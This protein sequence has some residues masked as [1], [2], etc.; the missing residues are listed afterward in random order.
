MHFPFKLMILSKRLI[1]WYLHNKRDLP[2]RNTLNPYNIKFFMNIR[3]YLKMK[4]AHY[5][6]EANPEDLPTY[7]RMDLN[8]SKAIDENAVVTLDIRNLLDR[9]NH[10]PSLYGAEDGIEEPGI[11]VL[12]RVSYK[13]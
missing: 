7:W 12:L 5:N 3:F 1:Y 10:I 2:W 8:I 11:S 4:E 6:R 9:K 13:F